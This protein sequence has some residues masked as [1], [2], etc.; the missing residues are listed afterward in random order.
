MIKQKNAARN[1]KSTFWQPWWLTII[2]CQSGIQALYF[3]LIRFVFI[4]NNIL[5]LFPFILHWLT[6]VT[7][8]A[9]YKLLCSKLMVFMSLKWE[10]QIGLFWPFIEWCVGVSYRNIGKLLYVEKLQI[11][12]SRVNS[13]LSN[14]FLFKKTVG[15]K[16]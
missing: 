4:S 14:I 8:Q 1:D 5:F 9:C 11:V 16:L 7:K 15:M 3:L 13:Q 10:C 6:K 2:S 12:L